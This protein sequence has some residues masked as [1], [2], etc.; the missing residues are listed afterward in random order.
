MTENYLT[1]TVSSGKVEKAGFR[2]TERRFTTSVVPLTE[3]DF[4]QVT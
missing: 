4:E 2:G 1:E 3:C